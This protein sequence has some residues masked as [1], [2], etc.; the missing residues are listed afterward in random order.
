MTPVKLVSMFGFGKK[1]DLSE[2]KSPKPGPHIAAQE[3]NTPM[4]EDVT[5]MMAQELPIMDSHQRA[6]VYEILREYNG[7]TIETQDQLPA[8]IR[9]LMDLD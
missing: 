7:P 3:T 8:E 1:K 2:E 9:Q 6:R 4:S 5:L